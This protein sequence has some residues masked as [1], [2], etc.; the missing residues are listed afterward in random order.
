M[1]ISLIEHFFFYYCMSVISL[2]R[3]VSLIDIDLSSIDINQC[4]HDNR[5]EQNEGDVFFDTFR[6]TH[7][8]QPTTKVNNEEC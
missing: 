5:D 2:C 1:T 6:G 4:D 7:K 3:G 8:C